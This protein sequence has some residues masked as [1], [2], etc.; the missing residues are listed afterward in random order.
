MVPLAH[1]KTC[2]IADVRGCFS[3][4]FEGRSR[5][6]GGHSKYVIPACCWAYHCAPWVPFGGCDS[7]GLRPAL[8]CT[9]GRGRSSSC[10]FPARQTGGNAMVMEPLQHSDMVD[11]R[12]SAQ[13]SSC[14]ITLGWPRTARASILTQQ[15]FMIDDGRYSAL[16][17]SMVS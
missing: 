12:P 7:V 3:A 1:F 11:R 4:E 6:G 17:R 8:S 16:S 5:Q 14:K 13:Q 9:V 15:I 10:S 2:L